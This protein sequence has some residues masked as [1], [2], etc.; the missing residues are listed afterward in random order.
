MKMLYDLITTHLNATRIFYPSYLDN[1]HEICTMYDEYTN[2]ASKIGPLI[3]EHPC[4]ISILAAI[5][6]DNWSSPREV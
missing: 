6:Y 5:S 1:I 3:L 4:T 2:M